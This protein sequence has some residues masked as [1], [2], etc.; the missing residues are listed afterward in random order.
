MAVSLAFEARHHWLFAVSDAA[1]Y[2][3]LASG[4]LHSIAQPFASRQL[5]AG[6]VR[7]LAL[8]L[9][10]PVNQAF[11]LQGSVCLVLLLIAVYALFVRS[12]APRWML[13]AFAVLPFWPHLF[14]GLAVP[15]LWYAFLLAGFLWLL[16]KRQLL[17]AAAMMFP[18]MISRE[19]TSLTLVCFL[20]AA[21][22][23][24]RW[25]GR[26]VAVAATL[27]GSALVEHL[28]HGN[29]GNIEHLPQSVYLLLKVPWNFL[30]NVLGILPWSNVY[31]VFCLGKPPIWQHAFS[32]GPVTAIGVCGYQPTRPLI[33]LADALTIFGLLPLLTAFLLWRLRRSRRRATLAQPNRSVLLR[34]C[35]IFG[36]ISYLIA[37]LLGVA[38]SRL[39]GYGWPLL[40]VA[41]PL[42]FDELPGSG[43]KPRH[44]LA[45]LAFLALHF[46]ACSLI[47]FGW[48]LV[49]APYAIALNAAGF[50]LLL[51]WWGPASPVTSSR[52]KNPLENPVS[53]AL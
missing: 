8:L 12:L 20:I 40:L 50:L 11:I 51:W 21:W 1:W 24:L 30:T 32:F 49:I 2:R 23:P 25:P 31:T 53:T 6:V 48:E 3:L 44:P 26:I 38:A 28:T 36:G 17:L 46:A 5:G 45:A 22:K 18:L 43:L 34:F 52:S 14:D 39:F 16:Y 27:A 13:A 33:C 35:L 9:H 10:W 37:P 19:S 47:F 4:E 29:P 41:L 7:I 15:D 42:L